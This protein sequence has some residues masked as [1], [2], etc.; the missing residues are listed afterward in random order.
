MFIITDHARDR[1]NERVSVN[2]SKMVKMT[3]KAWKSTQT[4]PRINQMEYTAKHIHE[5]DPA[6]FRF[7]MG[8]IFVFQTRRKGAAKVLLTVIDPHKPVKKKLY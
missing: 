6:V 1:F 5:G 4:V 7:F 2:P 8:Y 3:E